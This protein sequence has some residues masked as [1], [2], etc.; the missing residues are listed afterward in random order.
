V[1]TD[2]SFANNYGFTLQIGFV[3]ILADKHNKANIIHWSLIK[4]KRVTQSVLASELYGIAHGFDIGA[5]IK[6]TL[7]KILQIETLSLLLYTDSKS[8]YGCLV[9]LGT[10]QEKRLMVNLMCLRQSYERREI[11]EIK[12]IDEDNNPANAITKSSHA[13]HYKT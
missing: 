1:F 2:S 4:C 13:K 11:T 8:L 5:I 12:W 9:K 7:E 10:T 6:S 3:I